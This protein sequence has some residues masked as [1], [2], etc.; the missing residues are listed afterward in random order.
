MRFLTVNSVGVM[1]AQA[2]LGITLYGL[3]VET[4]SALLASDFLVLLV[5]VL[6]GGSGYIYVFWASGVLQQSG[7]ARTFGS[8]IWAATAAAI[9]LNLT[10]M[11]A[12]DRWGS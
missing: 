5:P 3:G 9:S 6:L 11:V 4:Q 12:F 10:L 1:L 2:A 8:V 7:G